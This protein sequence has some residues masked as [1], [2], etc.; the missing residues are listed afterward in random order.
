[1]CQSEATPSSA[2]YWHIGD[3]TRRFDKLRSAKP[4]R[5]KQNTSHEDRIVRTGDLGRKQAPAKAEQNQI[6]SRPHRLRCRRFWPID[7]GCGS[8]RGSL[9]AIAPAC[10]SASSGR[11]RAA[12]KH[13]PGDALPK[14]AI[15]ARRLS[16]GR[17]CRAD[18]MRPE[19]PIQAGSY[20]WLSGTRARGTHAVRGTTISRWNYKCCGGNRPAGKTNHRRKPSFTQTQRHRERSARQRKCE[21]LRLGPVHQGQVIS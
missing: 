8:L 19:M 7:H 12:R 6:A 2:L 17:L 9:R 10:S 18:M 13:G 16:Y 5:R 11:C 21:P 20:K 3:T 1:M 15:C 14:R 4:Q